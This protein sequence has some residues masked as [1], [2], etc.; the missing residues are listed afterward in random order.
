MSYNIKTISSFDKDFKRLHKRYRSLTDDLR[1]IIEQLLQNPLLG[2]DLGHG[3]RKVRMPVKSKNTGKSGGAR[4]ITY[5]DV[6]IEKSEGDIYLLSIYDK[7][8]QANISDKELRH[9]IG[10]IFA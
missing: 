2:T 5:V 8:E 3:I 7:S 6:I 4:L 9:L 1:Q 10:E